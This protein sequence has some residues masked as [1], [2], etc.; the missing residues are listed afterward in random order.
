[1]IDLDDWRDYQRSYSKANFKID[2]KMISEHGQ[3]K[4]KRLL[5]AGIRYAIDSGQILKEDIRTAMDTLEKVENCA[6]A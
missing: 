3:S 1:M 2:E 6:N 4:C 5:A